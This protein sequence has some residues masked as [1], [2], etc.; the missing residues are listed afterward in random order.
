M[1]YIKKNREP[2][3]FTSWKALANDYWQPSWDNNFQAPEKPIV[4]DALLKE[5]GFIC[6]YCGM[7]ITR[8]ASHIEHL[9]PRSQYPSLALEYTNLIASCQGE[10][11]EPPPIPV[12]C[13][14]EKKYWY[15]AKLMV[16]P[17]EPNCEAFF[18]YTG[19]G[20]IQPTDDPL[21][22]DAAITTIEKL[23]LN[24]D[25]LKNMRKLA[26]DAAL[27]ATQGLSYEEIQK[28]V[29]GYNELNNTGEYTPFCA[30][31]I[32]ILKNYF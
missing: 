16:S 4:H 9:K 20:E 6:C 5:Q 8:Q 2:G 15:E 10:S 30:A 17:L 23:A 18:K 27:D 21:K 26:I 32:Y 14:H 24:I 22:Q 19:A 3:Q 25:K 1:K 13:G 28:L 29:Q 12:H 31:I 11:E 7:R